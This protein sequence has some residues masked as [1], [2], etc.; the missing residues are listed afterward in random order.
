M[1]GPTTLTITGDSVAFTTVTL[2]TGSYA[3][4]LEAK[5]TW[6]NTTTKVFPFDLP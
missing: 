2:G 4:S 1:N 3:F 6:G 5:D